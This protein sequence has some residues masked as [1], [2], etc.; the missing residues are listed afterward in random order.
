MP[1]GINVKK[2]GTSEFLRDAKDPRQSSELE[3]APT[4]WVTVPEPMTLDVVVWSLVTQP[5]KYA[6]HAYSWDEPKSP[7]S[8]AADAATAVPQR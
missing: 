4:A 8:P 7:L 2:K 1:V 5:A 3:L 6:L